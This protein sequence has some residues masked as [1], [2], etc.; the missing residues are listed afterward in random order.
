MGRIPGQASIISNLSLGYDLGRFSGRVSAI[1]QDN[2]LNNIGKLAL[3]D[4]YVGESL[5]WDVAA[6]YKL[7]K[8]GRWTIL[9]NLNNLSNQAEVAFLGS[10][11]RLQEDEI[12][13]WTGDIGI[14][15]R[16]SR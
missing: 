13:G 10:S 3:L 7:D 1:Y 6:K 16:L 2:T 14:Q 12:F 11:N 4:S 5:R 15:Y 8:K 9:L